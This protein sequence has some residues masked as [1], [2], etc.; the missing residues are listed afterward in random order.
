M[1]AA[2]NG[3]P[4]SPSRDCEADVDLEHRLAN[5]LEGRHVPEREAVHIEA[6]GG[7]VVIRGRLTS[8]HARWLC[9]ECCRH[10]A[11]VIRL[12]DQLELGPRANQ[13][14]RAA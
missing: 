8:T 10:V 13:R 12:V 1:V 9:V 2:R 6:H 7:T 14:A 11:G 4:I 3:K 5:F